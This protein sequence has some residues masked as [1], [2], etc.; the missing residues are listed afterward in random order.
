MR[1]LREGPPARGVRIIGYVRKPE[2]FAGMF[3]PPKA[4]TPF[5]GAK[6][7]LTGS[8]GTTIVT[9]DQDGI[10]EVDGLPLDNYTL[11]LALP[12]TQF[13]EDQEVKKNALIRNS[14]SERDFYV[15]WNG[16]VEGTVRDITGGPAGAW[17]E[18]QNP[19]GTDVGP[20]IDSFQRNDKNGS[21]RI[22]KIYPGR[23]ILTINPFGP[24]EDSPY[25]PLSYPSAI[26]AEDARVLDIAVGQHT[27][28]LDFIVS[29][30][31][32]RKLQVRVTWPDGRPVAGASVYVA[33]EHTKAYV[34]LNETG[35][36]RV[37]DHNGL[38][39]IPVFGSSRIRV[40]AAKSI[41]DEKTGVISSRY[42]PPVELEADKLPGK[43]DL[44]V[45]LLAL[46]HSR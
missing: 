20:S 44:V 21:Y 42:S 36:S 8:S 37:T 25:A 32:E 12:D 35:D 13:A 23:Y 1:V 39:Y 41:E 3:T 46:P 27:K 11:R 30:L 15:V 18:L 45:S 40:H 33:Y 9:T 2:P 7:S 34:L 14:L 38:A 19:D 31:P 4:H 29:R 16:S 22:G 26:R 24:S 10:Y 17:V 28:N 5:T 43:I 6:I